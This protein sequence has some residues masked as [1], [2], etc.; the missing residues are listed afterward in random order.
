[1][2]C[3]CPCATQGFE[4]GR[5]GAPS[6][7]PIFRLPKYSAPESQDDIHLGLDMRKGM[8]DGIRCC[9]VVVVIAS[10]DY[11]A[12][13]L[14][15]GVAIRHAPIET[16]NSPSQAS[17]NCQF[18]LGVLRDS[19]KPFVVA[20]GEPGPRSWASSEFTMMLRL[21]THKYADLRAAAAVNVESSDDS[22][23]LP[24]INA[25]LQGT[26][27]LPALLDLVRQ[28]R[29]TGIEPSSVG[30]GAR[31]VTT[32]SQSLS[33]ASLP[34]ASISSSGGSFFSLGTVSDAP[35]GGPLFSSA[36]GPA[37]HPSPAAPAEAPQ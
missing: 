17:E 24:Q 2:L 20:I 4:F 34:L 8:R 26:N 30:G 12:R 25:E 9:D 37:L 3:T 14:Y 31:A 27:A 16:P 6:H 15:A 29:A 10:P 7:S 36:G 22:D 28:A 18:E 23:A 35:A 13:E 11:Q 21:D 5:C 1:M 33:G 19:C 32:S